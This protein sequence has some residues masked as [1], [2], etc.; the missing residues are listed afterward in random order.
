MMSGFKKNI[1]RRR[2]SR[3]DSFAKKVR[4]GLYDEYVGR[5]KFELRP[6]LVVTIVREGERLISESSSGQTNVLSARSRRR[7]EL[8]AT[9]FDG[10]GKFVK[11][12]AGRIS[13]LVYYEFGQ[14]MGLARKI[15]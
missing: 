3:N 14:E 9:E 1:S 6:D 13:H 2:P 15:S 5:Y 12:D 8:I 10:L 11:D 7:N 4:A